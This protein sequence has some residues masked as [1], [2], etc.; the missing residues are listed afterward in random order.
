MTLSSYT[1]D[2]PTVS[3]DYNGQWLP[4]EVEQTYEAAFMNLL[5]ECESYEEFMVK[6]DLACNE[7]DASYFGFN[8]ADELLQF[9]KDY[10]IGGFVIGG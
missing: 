10:Y 1:S 9:V 4:D 5:N 2:L 8:N 6:S 3:C 7:Y